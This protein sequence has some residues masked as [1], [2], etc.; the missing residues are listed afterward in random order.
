MTLIETARLRL[1]P[2]IRED[3]ELIV[4]MDADPEVRRFMGGPLDSADHRKEV[5]ANMVVAR[6]NHWYWTIERR[7]RAGFLGMCALRPLEGTA[8]I[9]MGWRLLP[10]HWRQG[11]ATE[12]AHAVLDHALRV[13]GIDPLMAIVD[14]RNLPSIRVAEKIGMRRT[15]TAYHYGTEQILFRADAGELIGLVGTS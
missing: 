11:F 7:D 13:L 9:C 12:A 4:I 2:R 14:P 8:F 5:L 10:Q 15:G 6:P 1:R 3:V